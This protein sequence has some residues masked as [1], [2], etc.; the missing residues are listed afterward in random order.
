VKKHLNLLGVEGKAIGRDL[1]V[2]LL[3]SG[4]KV[5]IAGDLWSDKGMGLFGIYAH[6]IVDWSTGC[7]KALIGL[8]ACSSARHTAENIAVSGQRPRSLT[9]A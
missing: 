3:R 2:R 7:E 1:C 8:V 5:S 9:S 4:V 6:G